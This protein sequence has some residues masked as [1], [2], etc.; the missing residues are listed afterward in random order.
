MPKNLLI[1]LIILAVL[2]IV[3]LG[4][5]VGYRFDVRGLE[6][7]IQTQYREDK[8]EYDSFWKSVAESSQVPAKYAADMEQLLTADTSGK[9][10]EGGSNALMLWAADRNITLDSGTYVQLQRTIETG[11]NKFER[12]QRTLLA[13]QESLRNL[14]D[15]TWSGALFGGLVELRAQTGKDRPTEDDDGDGRLTVLD[16]MIMTSDKTETAF[17]TGKAD[18]LDVFGK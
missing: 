2:I 6:N 4:S 16:Y 15:T 17:K 3:P 14:R 13:K 8:N 5:C 1:G 10:G 7:T 9:Y 18:A 12:A 11:R